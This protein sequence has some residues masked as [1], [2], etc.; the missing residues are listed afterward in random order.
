MESARHPIS[1]IAINDADA[2]KVFYRDTLGLDLIE[3]SPFALVFFDGPH[4]LRV[5]IVP[6]YNP[7]THTAYGWRVSDIEQAMRILTGK[8]VQF[9][10]FEGLTQSAEGVW[11][12]P[13]KSK[14]AWFRDPCGNTLSVTQFS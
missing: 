9:L 13:D 1:F 6:G 8:G 12:T 3:Q 4:M 10:Q 2:A 14:I 5:Q 11:S 7:P